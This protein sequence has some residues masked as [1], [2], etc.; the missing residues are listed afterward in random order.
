M[1]GSSRRPEILAE[2]PGDTG[3]SFTLSGTTYFR[4]LLSQGT[5]RTQTA[6]Y[7]VSGLGVTQ[8][9]GY[10]GTINDNWSRP[11]NYARLSIN[12][13]GRHAG[14]YD[15]RY[16]GM[17]VRVNTPIPYGAQSVT[18]MIERSH[19]NNHYGLG[20]ATFIVSQ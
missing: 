12:V 16:G 11:D 1:L 4:G 7:N 8:L 2:R 9:T 14:S 13:D 15:M 19:G 5:R 10:F 20:D 17:P 18:I 3:G 6:V